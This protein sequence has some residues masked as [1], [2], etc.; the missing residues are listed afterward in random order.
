[1]FVVLGLV[2][3]LSISLAV[4]AVLSSGTTRL[5]VEAESQLVGGVAPQTS[6]ADIFDGQEVEVSRFAGRYVVVNFFASWCPPCVREHEQLRSLRESS[7]FA[8]IMVLFQ[9]KVSDVSRF[10]SSR[11]KPQ[12]PVI[13]DAG[14]HIASA[15]GVLSP[16]QTFVI[17]PDGRVVTRFL[18][19]ITSSGVV[20]VIERDRK[21]RN[22]P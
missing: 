4:R 3:A 18:G 20:D 1:L 16:P 2:L 17:G 13:E 7:D 15:Y 22:G 12:W 5:D 21:R 14:Q 8:V 10:F 6:G 9:N 19:E 11:G